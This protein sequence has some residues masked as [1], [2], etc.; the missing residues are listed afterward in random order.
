MSLEWNRRARLGHTKTTTVPIG[1]VTGQDGTEE[2]T[3]GKDSGDEGVVGGSQ[4]LCAFTFNQLNEDFGAGD[5][6]DVSRA[7]RSQ[8]QSKFNA[9]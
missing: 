4:R 8:S 7:S 3:S 5:T 9:R 6:V 1:K 2:G